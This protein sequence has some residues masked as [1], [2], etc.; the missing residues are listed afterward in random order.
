MLH[1]VVPAGFEDVV[2]ADDVALDV[3]VRIGDRVADSRLRGKVHHHRRPFLPED[4][5]H[6]LPLRNRTPHEPPPRSGRGLAPIRPGSD[7]RSRNFSA[8]GS[9]PGGSDICPSGAA[10][11]R[12]G[13]PIRASSGSGGSLCPF[14]AAACRRGSPIRAG[15]PGGESFDL[16]ETLVLDVD[17]VVV[18]DGIDSHHPDVLHLGQQPPDEVRPD[19]AGS[20]GHQYGLSFQRNIFF[21]HIHQ[22]SK[23]KYLTLS[24]FIVSSGIRATGRAHLR[25]HPRNQLWP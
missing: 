24:C 14:G 19:E 4:P 9:G 1:G 16:A 25:P 3:G 17:I 7:S 6:N 22:L 13:S 5:L 20:T 21:Q 11:S 2:E 15:S 18:G 10:A 12:R 8:I 23:N